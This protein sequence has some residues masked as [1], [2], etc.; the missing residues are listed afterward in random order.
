MSE[1]KKSAKGLQNVLTFAA[2]NGVRVHTAG[3]KSGDI[4]VIDNKETIESLIKEIN[5]T[6]YAEISCTVNGTKQ[7]KSVG[8]LYRSF[9]L[10]ESDEK[11]QRPNDFSTLSECLEKL[12]GQKVKLIKIEE[13]KAPNFNTQIY[14]PITCFKVEIVK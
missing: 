14:E 6:K 10:D 9:K 5:G 2:E 12:C 7:F 8:S 13:A 11:F 1:I 4:L 3:F